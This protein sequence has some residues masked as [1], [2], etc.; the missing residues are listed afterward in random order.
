MVVQFPE[1]PIIGW[2]A[3]WARMRNLQGSVGQVESELTIRWE[4][5][6]SVDR[7]ERPPGQRLRL[8]VSDRD[9]VS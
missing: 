3:W 5:R 7:K 1:T 9:L 2:M 6:K 8:C 4:E